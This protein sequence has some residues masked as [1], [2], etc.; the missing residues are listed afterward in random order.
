M[1]ILGKKPTKININASNFSKCCLRLYAIWFPIRWI[2]TPFITKI[3][4]SHLWFIETLGWKSSSFLNCQNS[5]TRCKKRFNLLGYFKEA[6]ISFPTMQSVDRTF[7]YFSAERIPAASPVQWKTSLDV[8]TT[9]CSIF[10][11]ENISN[12]Q[13]SIQDVVIWLQSNIHSNGLGKINCTW[14]CIF[15]INI[16]IHF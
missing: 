5:G 2:A 1:W 6:L 4:S 14:N 9:W 16:I 8:T 3:P 15:F 12:K 13:L 7:L 10:S 11:T